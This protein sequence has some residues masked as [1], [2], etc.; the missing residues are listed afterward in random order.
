MDRNL[1]NQVY[2]KRLHL[3]TLSNLAMCLKHWAPKVPA[4][5]LCSSLARSATFLCPWGW[6]GLKMSLPRPFCGQF[7]LLLCCLKSICNG[8][9][10]LSAPASSKSSPPIPKGWWE[11]SGLSFVSLQP[12][13]LAVLLC[14]SCW[15]MTSP[16]S[17]PHGGLMQPWA[18]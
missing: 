17:L 1:P 5:S 7:P 14:R 4:E 18:M 9:K 2:W 13:K 8:C 11:A 3:E 6:M 10:R 15:T 12:C 16:F